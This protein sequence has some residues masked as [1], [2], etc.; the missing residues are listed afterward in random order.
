MRL[1]ADWVQEGGGPNGNDRGG[2][3]MR[4][5]LCHVKSE[6]AAG[7]CSSGHSISLLPGDRAVLLH[8]LVKSANTNVA[9]LRAH[10]KQQGRLRKE[11]I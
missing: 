7:P 9:H 10:G 8:F 1:L 5:A 2:V 6:G 4:L 11:D 3:N